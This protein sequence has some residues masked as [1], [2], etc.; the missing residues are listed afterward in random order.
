MPSTRYVMQKY[1]YA[2]AKFSHMS[3]DLYNDSDSRVGLVC[4]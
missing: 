3:H 4:L 1:D 2:S